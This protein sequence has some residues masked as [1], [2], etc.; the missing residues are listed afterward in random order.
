MLCPPRSSATDLAL[1]VRPGQ[2]GAGSG[3]RHLGR[4][5]A[6]D[7]PHNCGRGKPASGKK[8]WDFL[9]SALANV[10]CHSGDSAYEY[11]SVPLFVTVF[12]HRDW[13]GSA[14]GPRHDSETGHKLDDN[15]AVTVNRD[16]RP[17]LRPRT[18]GAVYRADSDL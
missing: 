12:G 13:P 17:E 2:V 7:R 4:P 5:R 15:G 1:P 14:S 6:S 18:T 3:R 16:G 9:S 11:R 10:A 8:E